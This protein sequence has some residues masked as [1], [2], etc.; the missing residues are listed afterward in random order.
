ME[1]IIAITVWLVC[2]L[3]P[4][5]GLVF[6]TY[7]FISLP[8][9][10]QER[11]RSFLILLDAG[12]KDGHR[13]EDTIVSLAKTRDAGL[14]PRFQALAASLSSGTLSL[15]EALDTMPGFLPAQIT[16]ILRVGEKLGDIRK[17]MPAC[18]HLLKDSLAL[19]RNSVHYLMAATFATTPVAITILAVVQTYVLPQFQSVVAGMLEQVPPGLQLL[20]G[21]KN[22]ILFTEIVLLMIIWVT[23]S[24][25]I[26]TPPFYQWFERLFPAVCDRLNFTLPWRHKRLQRDFSSMLA[27][28]LDGGVPEPEAVTLAA[29][30]TANIVFIRR[31][32]R[33]VAALKQGVKLTEAIQLM[34]DSG[35]FRWR[36]TNAVHGREGFLKAIVGWNEALDAKAFQQQQATAQA[37][38]SGLVILNGL[39]VGFIVVSLFS[40]LIAIINAGELW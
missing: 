26:G 5:G 11:V 32:Q 28:L 27:M 37:V 8:L 12:I 19:T 23:A 21:H 38:T 30:C 22:E 18:R 13:V 35:E 14:G 25:Y 3:V 16:A 31:A 10:R 24:F 36:L 9:R 2:W 7:H 33:V 20:A 17:V 40:V 4:I 29:D 6:A 39:F 1:L 15:S 34:D